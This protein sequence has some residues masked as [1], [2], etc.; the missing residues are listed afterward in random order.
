MNLKPS[1]TPK[2]TGR[3]TIWSASGSL[4]KE[5]APFISTF[6]QNILGSSYKGYM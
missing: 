2:N 1:F 3:L 5:G 4:P 6:T